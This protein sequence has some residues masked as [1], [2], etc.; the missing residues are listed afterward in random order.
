MLILLEFAFII[1]TNKTKGLN[2]WLDKRIDK[3]TISATKKFRFW[4][5]GY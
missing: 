4:E 5:I 1:A 3:S 2:S